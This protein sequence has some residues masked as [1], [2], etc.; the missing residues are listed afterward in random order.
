M[1]RKISPFCSL[2]YCNINTNNTYIKVFLKGVPFVP[3]F[4]HT[5]PLYTYTH[6]YIF[7][8]IYLYIYLMEHMA[9][10][11]RALRPKGYRILMS[12]LYVHIYG[13]NALNQSKALN[14]N[15]PNSRR[16]YLLALLTD[17]YVF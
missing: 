17:D 13:N 15:L 10:G 11:V 16:G 8:F 9:Q 14:L 12:V 1:Y 3:N 2:N 4:F 5:T 7:F 6:I